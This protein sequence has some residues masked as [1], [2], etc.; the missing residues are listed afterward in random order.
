M[1]ETVPGQQY[2]QVRARHWRN[3]IAQ[4]R[5]YTL[6]ECTCEK[7][8][9]AEA[10]HH[11]YPGMLQTEWVVAGGQQVGIG[12]YD[13]NW[14]AKKVMPLDYRLTEDEL[15]QLHKRFPDWIMVTGRSNGHDHPIAHTSTRIVAK[16]LVDNLRQGTE[17]APRQVL[18]L[19]GNPG[20][21]EQHN[22]RNKNVRITTNVFPYTAKDHVRRA[23]KWGPTFAPDGTR[24]YYECDLREIESDDA[25][26]RDGALALNEYDEVIAVHS[27]YHFTPN[28]M[29]RTVNMMKDGAMLTVVMHKYDPASHDGT[30]N[31]GEQT[32][33]RYEQSGMKRIRQDNVD[34]HEHYAH[35]DN[36][37]V[38]ES[39]IWR[40]AED[41]QSDG[42]AANGSRC[43]A[44]TINKLCDD[45]YVVTFVKMPSVTYNYELEVGSRITAGP[46]LRAQTAHTSK[47]DK[48]TEST[49][50]V[51]WHI[52]GHQQSF[53][54]PKPA[55]KLFGDMRMAMS[56]VERTP[57]RFK[58]HVARTK[59]EY[60]KLRE[61]HDGLES[62][63]LGDIAAA[64]FWIDA[65]LDISRMTH[66]QL[67]KM[68]VAMAG[69]ALSHNG[70]GLSHGVARSILEVL[71]ITLDATTF[72]KGAASGVRLVA[73][74]LNSIK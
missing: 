55:R 33:E 30:I 47:S 18:D 1:L 34:T 36:G 7:A 38:F 61:K 41:E 4:M 68:R 14:P 5:P 56:M 42:R 63:C 12:K 46:E 35:L 29:C 13:A 17:T 15:K 59:R 72:R 19:F 31:C 3:I 62:N 40:H 54:L 51:T 11:N 44:W 8:A 71:Q 52:A 39:N 24:R 23:T 21:N 65:E 58:D 64:S 60:R 2:R 16:T 69:D 67:D 6:W 57:S 66:A 22:R 49:G 9:L 27:M 70:V 10:S 73:G 53:A 20:S 43:M 48:T 28:D 26:R 50:V 74:K 25:D 45:T 37:W 32:W